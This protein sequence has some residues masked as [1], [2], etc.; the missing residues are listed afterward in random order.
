MRISWN[1]FHA[2]AGSLEQQIVRFVR[3]Q[4]GDFMQ[5]VSMQHIDER[6]EAAMRARVGARIKHVQHRDVLRLQSRRQR[7]DDV[8]MVQRANRAVVAMDVVGKSVSREAF[9]RFFLFFR[10]TA[11]AD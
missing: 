5:T 2:F 8:L 7:D 3:D 1:A 4:I 11:L 9:I 10:L 6:I